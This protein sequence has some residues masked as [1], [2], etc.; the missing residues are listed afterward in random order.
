MSL[1]SALDVRPEVSEALAANQPV[2]ALESTLIAH[3]LPWPLNLATATASEEAVR[4]EGAVPAT[5]AV[6]QGR[7]TIGL[8]PWELEELAC[9]KDILK[10]SRRDL[11]LAVAQDRTAATTVA[12]TMFLAHRAGIRV[13][14][15]GGIGGAHRGTD[16]A[17]D[18]SAD[19]M[20]IARTPLAVVCAGAKSI[21]DLTRTLE[22]LETYG[23]PVVGYGTDDFP[24]FYLRSSGEP[25]SARVDTPR[26]AV[27]LLLAHW[28]LAGAGVVLAQPVVADVALEQEEFEKA[29]YQA[30]RQAA[31][32]GV[33]GK[34]LT[35]FLLG[36]LAE[37][38]E[39]KTLRAN[40][41][42]VIANARLAAQIARI[43]VE[44]EG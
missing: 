31:A 42:L 38:T 10:A 37:V 17:W 7:P 23:V 3:G 11:A 34:D 16:H 6:W 28:Q 24:A 39:G 26:Q 18:I 30:E 19:L 4:D 32:T 9:G 36:N 8:A 44:S 15:T 41:A 21:L 5:I 22:V 25:V 20:E 35:P 27:D 40:Q 33:R 12:A 2:V 14:A 13:M 29:L 1:S 43:L